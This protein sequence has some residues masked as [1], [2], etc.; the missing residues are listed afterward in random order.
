MLLELP[1]TVSSKHL[2]VKISSV[3]LVVYRTGEASS[4]FHKEFENALG[5]YGLMVSHKNGSK[6][7]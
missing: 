4:L 5:T 2:C 7:T 3:G 6:T 1:S